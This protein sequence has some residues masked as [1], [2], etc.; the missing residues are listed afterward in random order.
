[1]VRENL[2]RQ[3]LTQH[4]QELE[5]RGREER[6]RQSGPRERRDLRQQHG[7]RVVGPGSNRQEA[8]AVEGSEVRRLTFTSSLVAIALC[9]LP[10]EASSLFKM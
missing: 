8:A 2:L 7:H 10:L 9:R 1:M 6:K 4:Q 3:S 5:W